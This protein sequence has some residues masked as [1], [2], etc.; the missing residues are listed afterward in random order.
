LLLLEHALLVPIHDLLS[1]QLITFQ[2][3]MWKELF[4]VRLHLY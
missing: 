4:Q 2:K 3:E 1:D